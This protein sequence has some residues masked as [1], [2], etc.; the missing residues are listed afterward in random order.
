MKRAIIRALVPFLF[1]LTANAEVRDFRL[2]LPLVETLPNGLKVAWF[3]DDRLP[4][5]DLGMLIGSGTRND[6]K[7]KSGTVELLSRLL[8]RGANGFSAHS[9]AEKIES[10]GATGFVAS[11]EES[12]T[13]GMHGLAQDSEELLQY[14]SWIALKPTLS[15]P[16]FKK[17]KEKIKESWKHLPD[18][19]EALAGFV[20]GRAMLGGTPYGRGSL[21]DLKEYGRLELADIQA[22]HKTHFTPKN[23]LLLVVGRVDQASFRE[24]ITATFGSWK[25]NSPKKTTVFFRDPR[26]SINLQKKMKV[27]D[28]EILVVDRP[29]LPQAQVR[30]GFRVPGIKS[31]KRYS[32]AVANALLG[33]YFNSRLNLIVRDKLGLAY[34][35]QSSLVYYKDFAFFVVSSATAATTAGQLLVETV[36]QLRLM[37]AADVLTEEVTVAKDFLLGGYP[38]SVSTLGSV[39]SRW[40]NGY[41]YG[42]GPDYLNEFMPNISAVTRESVVQALDEAFHIDEMLIVVAGDAKQ[43]EKSLKEKGFKRVRK[44]PASSLL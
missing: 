16:E 12:I 17:E 25:G 31:D 27:E 37:K 18:S 3:L 40:M 42:F 22:F 44:V 29:G 1:C 28:R 26:T 32:L 41:A 2:P 9:M 5:V 38:L 4:L 34:G 36:R 21:Q 30:L 10:L 11:D 15:L 8:E 14:L 24:K 19:A 20:F 33:E 35:I 43:I 39:A 6:P 13:L 7:G 23:A